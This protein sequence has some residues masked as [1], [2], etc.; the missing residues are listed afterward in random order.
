MLSVTLT[1]KLSV[2]LQIFEQFFISLDL[3]SYTVLQEIQLALHI[4]QLP[5]LLQEVKVMAR[6]DT[7]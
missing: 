1:K 5:G 6:S 2:V 3:L 4:I 7:G